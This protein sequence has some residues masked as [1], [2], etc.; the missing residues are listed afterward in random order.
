MAAALDDDA[1]AEEQHARYAA[2]RATLRA[3]LEGAGF[4]IDHSEA[5]LYLWA[6]RDEDCWDTVVRLAD[7]GILVAP[8]HVLRPRRARGTSGSPSPPP[9]SASPPLP[10]GSEPVE[11]RAAARR[12]VDGCVDVAPGIAKRAVLRVSATA[13]SW[14]WSKVSA[15][16]ASAMV[17]G[18]AH[19]R[20]RL[21][22]HDGVLGVRAQDDALAVDAGDGAAEP[23]PVHQH[24][25][26]QVV[27]LGTAQRRTDGEDRRDLC[28]RTPT[29]PGLMP[30][31][32]PGSALEHQRRARADR[33]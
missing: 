4:R 32:P 29:P 20:D 28:I 23:V 6:T 19:R 22:P 8:G 17:S 10:L 12:P 11:R 27:V 2:R 18:I 9:T 16:G 30:K 15:T 33:V 31:A 13:S 3:A 25:D 14:C 7:L 5:S 21:E 24:L 26:R 1:H